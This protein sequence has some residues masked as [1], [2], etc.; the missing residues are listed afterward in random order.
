MDDKNDKKSSMR[1]VLITFYL[2][3]WKLFDFTKAIEFKQFEVYKKTKRTRTSLKIL[4]RIT[5]C[6]KE[7]IHFHIFFMSKL[8]A[9][10]YR[11]IKYNLTKIENRIY[12]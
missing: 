8:Y 4:I 12:K 7:N 3:S 11:K 1:N 9:N 10:I 5:I 2:L 6:V